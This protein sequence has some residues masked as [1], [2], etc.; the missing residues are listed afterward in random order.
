MPANPQGGT[1]AEFDLGKLPATG[2]E[3]VAQATACVA[4]LERSL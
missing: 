3:A 2:Q 1:A 4:Q